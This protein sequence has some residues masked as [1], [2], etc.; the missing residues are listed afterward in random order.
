MERRKLMGNILKQFRKRKNLLLED[1]SNGINKSKSWIS[2]LENGLATT[3]MDSLD[4]LL[5][6]YERS[7]EDFLHAVVN[8]QQQNRTINGSI[9]VKGDEK[10]AVTVFPDKWEILELDG[11]VYK[12]P[13][14]ILDNSFLDA[15]PLI[16]KPEKSVEKMVNKGEQIWYILRGKV[17]IDF[18]YTE[19]TENP[20]YSEEL[21]PGCL[22]HIKPSLCHKATNYDKSEE[23][24]ILVV[25]C[26]IV[27]VLHDPIDQGS[28]NDCKIK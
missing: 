20:D 1:V 13:P 6:F 7:W 23:V 17:T 14:H 24:E 28:F 3:T 5:L 8:Y 16:I 27:R 2:M 10:Y 12:T 25:R 9:F 19:S 15:S 11:L 21:T 18:F 26:S 4:E 22:V